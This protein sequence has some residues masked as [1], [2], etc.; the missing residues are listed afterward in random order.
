MTHI[1]VVYDPDLGA[2]A[3]A[4]DDDGTLVATA[5]D[6]RDSGTYV[7]IDEAGFFAATGQLLPDEMWSSALEPRS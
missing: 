5:A 4:Y 2:V 3:A 1:E 7:A 6:Y